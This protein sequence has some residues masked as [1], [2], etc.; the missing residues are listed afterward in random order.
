MS[1]F[2][3]FSTRNVEKIEYKRLNITGIILQP[4]LR[5]IY[6]FYM[7]VILC[8]LYKAIL[9]KYFNYRAFNLSRNF[10]SRDLTFPLL[11]EFFLLLFSFFIS[12]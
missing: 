4:F 10:I 11:E 9:V 2:M 6:R 8:T 5:I 1:S 12:L 3:F 7:G